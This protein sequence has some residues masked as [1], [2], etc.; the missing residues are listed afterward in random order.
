MIHGT[1]PLGVHGETW[2]VNTVG[3]RIDPHL[4]GASSGSE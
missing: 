2:I 3:K 1:L 4:L